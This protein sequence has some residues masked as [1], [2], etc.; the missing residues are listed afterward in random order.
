MARRTKEEAEETRKS[1]LAAALEIF[2]EKGYSRTTF[3]EI[4]RRINLTKGAIY[5]HFR[6][7][8][9]ILTEIIRKGFSSTHE[10]MEKAVRPENG[11][12]AMMDFMEFE[13]KIIKN[14][15][16][17]RQLMFFLLFQMEWSEA[18]LNKIT[19]EIYEVIQYPESLMR[20]ILTKAREK[21]EIRAD[22]DIDSAVYTILFIWQGII[23]NIVKPHIPVSYDKLINDSYNIITNGLKKERSE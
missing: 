20:E 1:I 12:A 14:R 9:D 21:D 4:A 19:K 8:T 3:D 15:P 7:K 2:C 17:Y 22:T 13:I 11:L 5:W 6:N 16:V 10:G 18:I 23:R